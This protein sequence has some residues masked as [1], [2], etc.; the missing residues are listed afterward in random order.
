MCGRYTLYTTD[1]L[2]DRYRLEVSEAIHPNYNVAPSQTMPVV[3]IEGLRMMRWGLIPP[4]AKDE[5]IGYK[6]IN[7]RSETV[8]DKPMWEK[9]VM[10]RRCLVPAN[11]YYEWQKTAGGKRPYHIYLPIETIFSMAGIWETWK[12]DDKEWQTYSILTIS[13][14]HEMAPVHDR[15]PVIL[16]REDELQWLAADNKEDIRALLRPYEDGELRTY[17]VSQE[18]NMVKVNNKTLIG[19]V[20]SK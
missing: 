11:G 18:V 20:N 1:E 10:Q 7:A 12:H 9:P 16:H 17:E 8:F 5:K 15:M 6:L 13:P 3:T 2:E 19:P 14:N 4:W